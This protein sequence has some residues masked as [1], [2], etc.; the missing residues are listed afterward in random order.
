MVDK[1]LSASEGA[2]AVLLGPAKYILNA[3]NRS[4]VDKNALALLDM[5]DICCHDPQWRCSSEEDTIR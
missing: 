5:S 1:R 2:V 4:N 3:P